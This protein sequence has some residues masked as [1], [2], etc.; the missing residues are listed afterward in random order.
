MFWEISSGKPPFSKID[1]ININLKIINGIRETPVSNTP[2]E[3]QRLYKNCW[4]E[5]PSR[6]PDTEEVHKVLT[7]LLISYNDNNKIQIFITS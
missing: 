7:Q 5:L 4:D 6:R 3:Y 2:I 1:V